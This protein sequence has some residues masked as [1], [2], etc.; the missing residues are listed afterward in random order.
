MIEKIL[1]KAKQG[2]KLSNEEFLELLDID[3]DEDLEKLF[4]VAC[5]TIPMPGRPTGSPS[6]SCLAY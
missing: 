5:E 2:K 1:N 3:N 6:H 4:K